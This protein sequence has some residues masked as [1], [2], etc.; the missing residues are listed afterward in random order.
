MAF[1]GG[2]V[3]FPSLSEGD[4]GCKVKEAGQDVN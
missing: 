4:E 2:D 3:L 1:G